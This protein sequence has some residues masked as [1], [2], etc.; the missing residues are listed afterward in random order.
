MFQLRFHTTITFQ[1]V[2]VLSI[3]ALL[4]GRMAST[5]IESGTKTS[6]TFTD[7]FITPKTI[8]APFAFI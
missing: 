6:A 2:S 1:S 3:W 8:A 5:F 7:H 4:V